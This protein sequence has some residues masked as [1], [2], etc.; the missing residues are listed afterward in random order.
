MNK[1]E[2]GYPLSDLEELVLSVLAGGKELYGLQ[3]SKTIEE[4]SKGKLQIS[5]GTL[6]PA[7]RRLESKKFVKSHWDTNRSDE[8]GGARRRYY[9]IEALGEE[10]L[11]EK[12]AIRSN[13]TSYTPSFAHAKPELDF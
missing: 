6:Y 4:G 7:L 12:R 11:E 5:F 13:I 2:L 8:R 1:G 10:A 3:I 9:V